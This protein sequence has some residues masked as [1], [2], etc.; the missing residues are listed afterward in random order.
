M[1]KVFKTLMVGVILL[2]TGCNF[3]EKEAFEFSERPFSESDRTDDPSL[4]EDIPQPNSATSYWDQLGIDLDRF[5]DQAHLQYIGL[6]DQS[7]EKFFAQELEGAEITIA[8][9]DAGFDVDHD[10]LENRISKESQ[11]VGGQEPDFDYDRHKAR[12]SFH[13]THTTCLAAAGGSEEVIGV[14]PRAEVLLI[15]P[16]GGGASIYD[17]VENGIKLAAE[18]GADV[19][20]LSMGCANILDVNEGPNPCRQELTPTREQQFVDTL[21]E[22]TSQGVVI[23]M[24]AG[25]SGKE[26]NPANFL[27]FPIYLAKE[28]EGVISVTGVESST[29][30]LPD[31]QQT[32][33]KYFNYSDAYVELASPGVDSVQNQMGIKSCWSDTAD[34]ARKLGSSMAAPIAAGAAAL[35][36][37]YL[38]QN[39]IDIPVG[40]LAAEV[41]QVIT[42]GS[43]SNSSL[44]RLVKESR[45]L[46]LPSI[47]EFM[48]T[49]Y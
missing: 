12:G 33:N 49:R 20:N 36:I 37:R 46:N 38:E 30:L 28:V 42:Q 24:A 10:E 21:R 15:N 9:V 5:T 43:K 2:L 29:G 11:S 23:I 19:I 25:N 47:L 18:K 41:E 39:S 4:P 26:I 8:M 17:M 13:G 40:D 35:V 14:H 3:T 44:Q 6:N 16:M 27:P 22:I 34:Y 48:E 31:N 1:Q 45:D 32:G 7:M